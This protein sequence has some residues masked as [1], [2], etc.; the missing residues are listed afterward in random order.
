MEK[1]KKGDTVLILDIKRVGKVIELDHRYSYITGFHDI[2]YVIRC[3]EN[4]YMNY[5]R[6]EE[7]MVLLDGTDLISILYGVEEDE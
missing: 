4:H 2:L 3:T 1:F 7:S 6:C 5:Y